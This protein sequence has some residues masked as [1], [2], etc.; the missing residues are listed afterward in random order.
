MLS[1]FSGTV[2][3]TAAAHSAVTSVSF[4][5]SVVGNTSGAS[6]TSQVMFTLD[7]ETGFGSNPRVVQLVGR[8]EW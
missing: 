5:P 6:L 2:N 1:S 4:N 8:I 7:P 3:L